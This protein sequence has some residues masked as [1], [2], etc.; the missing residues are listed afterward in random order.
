MDRPK[1]IKDFYDG[2][3]AQ[4]ARTGVNER[5]QLIHRLARAHGLADGLRVL[6]MGCGIGTLTSLIVKDL[7]NGSLLAVDLSPVSIDRARA[8]LG[9]HRQLELR[10]ADVVTD[11]LPGP[12]DLIILPDILEHIPQ[13]LHPALFRRLRNDL[14]PH[15]RILIHSP[16]PHYSDHIRATRPEL[17]QVVDLALHIPD[18][19]S[20]AFAEGLILQHFQRHSIWTRDPD[21]MALVLSHPPAPGRYDPLPTATRSRTK[22]I[23]ERLSRWLRR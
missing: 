5:H 9:H 4:Q 16:E 22:R 17:M 11:P 3:A 8:L 10:V 21:Y 19:V 14:A 18:L 1:D 15:G 23:L 6:E 20:I 13:H 2:F 12:F 7:Q